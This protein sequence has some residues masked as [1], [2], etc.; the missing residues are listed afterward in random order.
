VK[1]EPTCATFSRESHIVYGSTSIAAAK[2]DVVYQSLLRFVVTLDD[3]RRAL[4]LLLGAK[5]DTCRYR[6]PPPL[7]LDQA[8]YGWFMI[9]DMCAI[10]CVYM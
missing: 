4:K 6:L 8:H 9:D 1:I 2:L 10:C 3:N 7:L 5:A